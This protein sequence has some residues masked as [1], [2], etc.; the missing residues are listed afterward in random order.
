M[1]PSE[2]QLEG[3]A[4]DTGEQGPPGVKG[5][6]GP[7]Q[8]FNARQVEGNIVPAGSGFQSRC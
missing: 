3:P 2:I 4:G 6:P 5:E 1:L 8:S 7:T